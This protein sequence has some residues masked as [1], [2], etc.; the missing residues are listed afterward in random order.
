MKQDW[1]NNLRDKMNDYQEKAP[2]GLWDD[3]EKTISDMPEYKEPSSQARIIRIKYASI[4]VVA[5][6]LL[7][8]IGFF[9]ADK[10]T[11]PTQ[12]SQSDN[13][14]FSVDSKQN[15]SNNTVTAK[16]T[17]LLANNTGKTVTRLT[18]RTA[19][20]H[21]EET[22][23]SNISTTPEI[24]DTSTEKS[25]TAQV[26]TKKEKVK[27]PRNPYSFTKSGLNTRQYRHRESGVKFNLYA[28]NIPTSA[29]NNNYTG[30]TMAANS[31]SNDIQYDIK[32]PFT[33]NIASVPNSNN[34]LT[35]VLVSNF[36]KKTDTNIKHRQPIRLGV[37]AAF[38]INRRWSVETG[39][40]YTYLTSDIY[41]GTTENNYQSVQKLHYIGIPLNLDYSI[42]KYK[43]I[44]VYVSGGGM[45]EFCIDGK[46][47]TD[48]ILSK[49]VES[50][51]EEKI[52]N[53]KTQWSVNAAAG[54]QYS[55]IPNMGIF[56]EPGVG[57]Y[58]DDGSDIQTIYKE[59]PT[60]FNLKLGLRIKIK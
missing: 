25:L 20:S 54:V 3:I 48:Y 43:N 41:S 23:N 5:A 46:L 30:V 56:I 14:H 42:W 29:S 34:S 22:S 27:K 44:N 32:S 16:Q 55:F 53:N 9:F 60:N 24:K 59:H 13:S 6:S 40:T 15:S 36:K 21:Y 33:T 7:C 4:I 17:T 45:A 52:K 10:T 19:A 58:F 35:D 49:K 57:Y 28:S 47:T 18:T 2:E 31:G 50:T 37:T 1:T 26:S 11:Q 38:D 39:V 51:G 12:L 8:L